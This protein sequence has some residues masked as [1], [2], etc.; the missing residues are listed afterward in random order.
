MLLSLSLLAVMTQAQNATQAWP[1]QVFSDSGNKTLELG[2][3]TGLTGLE[4]NFW[5]LP[6]RANDND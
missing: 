2:D 1:T 3:I 6:K 5:M 4:L